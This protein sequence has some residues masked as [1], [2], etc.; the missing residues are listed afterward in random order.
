[1]W[2]LKFFLSKAI[3]K[4]RLVVIDHD[5]TRHEFGSGVDGPHVVLRFTDSKI[6]FDIARNPDLAVGEGYMHGRIEFEDGSTIRDLLMLYAANKKPGARPHGWYNRMLYN[7]RLLLRPLHQANPLGLAAK[8]TRHHYDISGDFYRMW[9]DE[10]MNYTCA[11]F[12]DPSN[13]L[14]QAQRDKLDHVAT[15]LQLKRGMTVVDLGCGW[16]AAAIHFARHYGCDVTGINVSPE[17]L[18]F[19]RARVKDLGLED[20]VRFV[21]CDY[22]EAQGQY[23][24]VVSIGLMEHVGSRHFHQFFGQCSKL[25]KQDGAGLV[26]AIGRMAPP[27]ATGPFIRKYIFP[28]GSAPSMSEVFRATEFARLWVLDCE[29]LRMHYAWTLRHWHERFMARRDEAV[30]MFDEPFARMWEFYLVGAESWFEHGPNM[31]YQ[32]VISHE[33]DALPLTRDYMYA[34]R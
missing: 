25:M 4:G 32:C 8:N 24:R 34:A 28:G 2:L 19:A 29:I 33:R 14:E 26:H 30:A 17:Q 6:A 20:K 12:R 27:G 3:K 15:K 1:M 7:T 18:A 23:D 10:E 5:G 21:E 9:L 31:I 16:G 13:S 22:R 11:Y